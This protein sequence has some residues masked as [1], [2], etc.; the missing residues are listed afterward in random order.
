MENLFHL[1]LLTFLVGAIRAQIP[2]AGSQQPVVVV[3]GLSLGDI[4]NTGK[5]KETLRPAHFYGNTFQGENSV[6][7]FGK[8]IQFHGESGPIG[9]GVL[10]R[11][12][13]VRK[14]DAENAGSGEKWSTLG[15]ILKYYGTNN[16]FS[17]RFRTDAFRI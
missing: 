9:V 5:H 13:L 12:E 6:S 8:E 3:T 1:L 17:L 4:R 7:R 14:N 11:V 2:G 15:N 16:T 10:D